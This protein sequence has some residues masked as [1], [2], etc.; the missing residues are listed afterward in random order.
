MKKLWLLA[1]ILFVFTTAGPNLPGTAST[2]AFGGTS[3]WTDP[4]NI[5]A[6]DGIPTQVANGNGTTYLL[7]ATNF[8]FSIPAGSTINGITGTW[9]ASVTIGVSW[10]NVDQHAIKA[11]VVGGTPDGG[12]NQQDLTTSYAV[13]TAGGTTD[14]WNTTWTVSDVNNSGFGFGISCENANDP[15]DLS[16]DYMKLAVDYTEGASGRTHRVIGY[17]RGITKDIITK[18]N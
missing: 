8:G 7:K 9:E 11:G 17:G 16:V 2:E 12:A 13:Y 14:N 3:D 5:L 15:D 6:D 4:N 1:C 10:R 18:G